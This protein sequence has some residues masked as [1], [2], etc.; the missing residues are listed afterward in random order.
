MKY[1]GIDNRG[2]FKVH[3]VTSLTEI[4]SGDDAERRI[5][6]NK[7]DELL[8]YGTPLGLS[9]VGDIDIDADRISSGVIRV[10]R[11]P[12]EDIDIN[13]SQ[14]IDGIILPE[15]LPLN[16]ITKWGNRSTIFGV[17]MWSPPIWTMLDDTTIY[18]TLSYA[19]SSTIDV[20]TTVGLVAGREY[21]IKSDEHQEVIEVDTIT[22]GTRFV[23]TNPL[24]YEYPSD[25]TISRNSFD[26]TVPTS[27]VAS[28]NSV[29]YA[30][31]IYTSNN[32]ATKKIVITRTENDSLLKVYIKDTG[33]N[34]TWTEYPVTKS[35]NTGTSE[36]EEEY[37]VITKGYAEIKVVCEYGSGAE[38]VIIRQIF[39]LEP[40]SLFVI[41]SDT[42]FYVGTTGSDV[43]GDG[44][45]S[46]PWATIQYALDYLNDYIIMPGVFVD[47]IV[48]V[49]HY[50]CTEPVTIV[51]EQGTQISVKGETSYE[52]SLTSLQSITS[53]VS[54][55]FDIW[56]AT[57]TVSDTS[58]IEIGDY[59]SIYTVVSNNDM[60]P[61]LGCHRITSF[62]ADLSTVTISVRHASQTAESPAVCE[63]TATLHKVILDFSTQP[64]DDYGNIY[65]FY[66]SERQSNSGLRRIEQMVLVGPGYT[67]G[68]ESYIGVYL[69]GESVIWTANLGLVDWTKGIFIRDISSC[70][71][72]NA[73][74]SPVQ[75]YTD[76]KSICISRCYYGFHAGGG[77]QTGSDSEVVTIFS[78]NEYAVFV[79][80]ASIVRLPCEFIGS[81]LFAAYY[82]TSAFGYHI[83]CNYEGNCAAASRIFY[84][85]K[86][87]FLQLMAL[88]DR[89]N[90]CGTFSSPVVNTIGNENA[91]ID[92]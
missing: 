4:P 42:T 2:S 53:A 50:T 31:P 35:N 75:T 22:S 60:Y 48:G 87:A 57:F 40:T 66:A 51:H 7:E 79:S 58:E 19:N 45:Q 56:T 27:T 80:Q 65:G 81:S 70:K 72:K 44:T 32:D 83:N 91:Y 52:V 55:Y 24:T 30:G 71:F 88:T 36:Y 15:R 33:V 16:V 25:S 69:H 9:K 43:V 12:S 17:E 5:L 54:G 89:G 64:E 86:G 38:E 61:F 84:A 74:S 78:G 37:D 20:N 10:E 23:A 92:T 8:Y 67:T 28:N 3:E 77:A 49:G 82:T 26:T 47:I 59:L 41:S 18:V 62:D 34:T 63:L 11:I 73:N 85:D 76:A 46:N 1:Y 14:I 6:Y 68:S 29:Y 13:A 90:N 21:V 39:F